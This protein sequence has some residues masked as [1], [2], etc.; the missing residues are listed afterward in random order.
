M[1]FPAFIERDMM[2]T[3][4]S[5][6]YDPSAYMTPALMASSVGDIE[7]IGLL[8]DFSPSIPAASSDSERLLL[9]QVS[10]SVRCPTPTKMVL[11]WQWNGR[12]LVRPQTAACW[13][14][15]AGMDKMGEI[16][17]SWIEDVSCSST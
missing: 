7:Q 1:D 8:R 15:P 16:L 17:R 5:T 6:M 4:Y 13:T 14:S 11:S 9:E 12:L 3:A 10:I 2:C